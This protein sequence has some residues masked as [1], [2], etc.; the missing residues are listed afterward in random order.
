MPHHLHADQILGP[1]GVLAGRL[2][3]YQAREPQL[4]FA[5]AIDEAIAREAHVLSE[6]GTG[7]GKS[8]GYLVP[9][10]ANGKKAIVTT[11][12]KSL[13][14]Q[15]ANK[16]LPFLQANLEEALGRRIGFVYLKGKGN[17]ACDVRVG[18]LRGQMSFET[19]EAAAD[20]ER[21]DAWYATTATGDL[22]EINPPLHPSL[23]EMVNAEDC[24]H[25]GCPAGLAKEAAKG[26]D[27]VV[28]N[29]ALTLLDAML[30]AQTE[31]H[32]RVLPEAQILILDEAHGLAG[33]AQNILGHEVSLGAWN[34]LERRFRRLGGDKWGMEAI[35]VVA[36]LE[37]WSA[38][39]LA[40]MAQ[41]RERQVVL[42]DERAWGAP[43]VAGL[44][45]YEAE[46]RRMMPT[47][48]DEDDRDL[49]TKGCDQVASFAKRVEAIA[50]AGP[51]E[52]PDS[53]VRFASQE[54]AGK[55]VRVVLQARP[56]DVSAELREMIWRRYP[57]VVATSATLASPPVNGSAFDFFRRQTGFPAGK[58]VAE[59][60]APSPFPYETNS[61][62]YI[63]ARGV[64]SADKRRQPA[65]YFDQVAT[66]VERLFRASN[67][68]AFALFTSLNAMHEVAE[69]VGRKLPRHWRVFVQGDSSRTHIVDE[70]RR[71]DVMD[72]QPA[73]LF[74]TRSFFEGVDLPG[75]ALE[76]VILDSLPFPVPS[77]PIYAAQC[78]RIGRGVRDPREA[79][80]AHFFPLTIPMVATV[81]KQATG[82]L[83]R[84]D[85][86]KGV[87]AVLDRRLLEKGYGAGLIR[88]LPPMP[89]TE[90]FEAVRRVFPA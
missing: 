49:W 3:G 42:G 55:R 62:L 53:W 78:R 60:V 25:K 12:L 20:W 76:L 88:A 4:R 59:V 52:D 82:R 29:H 84:R 24:A 41:G 58:E 63:P 89:V 26:A 81:L 36:A 2:P 56:V 85:T 66:E 44:V 39:L 64:I 67:G 72:S 30:D 13:Q 33:V 16:D 48:L 17:Y 8:F 15:L 22:D 27:V 14:E 31:G 6:L 68:R 46:A 32:A 19:K 43:L 51:G 35:P 50:S 37:A 86:D 10:L 74:A 90:D 5:D 80:W 83:I 34:L 87:V 23:R 79:Q 73:V 38:D 69:R 11:T 71:E 18:K 75:R 7:T 45:A 54:G 21:F 61:T 70:F 40:R 77:E 57:T 47:M 65:L 1:T 28:A 9:A